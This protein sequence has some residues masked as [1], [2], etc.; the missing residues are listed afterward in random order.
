MPSILFEPER[1]AVESSQLTAFQH[2]CSS[3]VG[4]PLD[5]WAEFHAFSVRRFRDF[6]KLFTRWAPIELDGDA[7]T[8]CD[9]D[10]VEAA[11]FFPRARLSFAAHLLRCDSSADD[12]RTAL[13]ALDE[14]G[15]R[16]EVTR[17]ELRERALA[18]ARALLDAGIVPG[19]RVC[20]V[21]SN[22]A[23]AVIACLGA[24]A[25]GA[26]WS[27]TSPD[28][29][30]EG[31][32]DR[33]DQVRPRVLFYDAGYRYQG[34]VH[35][36]SPKIA[37]LA[38]ALGRMRLSVA[39]RGAA[40][41]RLRGVRS[42]EATSL[43]EL[44]RRGAAAPGPRAL[45]DLTRFAF[46]HPAYILFSSGTTG[47]PKCIVH[48]AGGTL[49]EHH[50]E[51]RLHCDLRPDDRL[52]FH[53][54]TAW[55]MW[56]WL[57]SA[58]ACKSTIVLYEGAATYPAVDS[59]WK[60]AARER[61]TVF[62]TSPSFL[63]ACKDHGVA[64]ELDFS[65]L[66]AVQSTGSVLPES[67]FRW[68]HASISHVPVQS[69][70][71]GTDILGCFLLGNPNL[72]VHTG[73]LQCKS[74]GLDVDVAPVEPPAEA[75][76][77][78]ALGYGELVC[79]TPFPSRPLGLLGDDGRRFHEAYFGRNGGAW[80]HGDWLEL[81]PTG[82]G[83]IHGRCDGVL[84]IRGV[85][86][87]PA[88]IYRALEHVSEVTA[89]MAIELREE[90]GHGSLV[91]LVVLRE[92][93]ALDAAL[94]R[95]L[96]G[97]IAARTSSAH[98]PSL[99][100]SVPELPV[101]YSGK[102]SERAATD[103]ANGRP[104][105]NGA[106]LRNP[107]SLED[108]RRAVAHARTASIDARIP[109]NGSTLEK[110]RAIWQEVLRVGVGNDDTFFELG[111]Q[112][113][114]A[115][116]LLGGVQRVFGVVLPMSALVHETPTVRKMAEAI[117]QRRIERTSSIVPLG[118]LRGDRPAYFVPGGGGLSLLMFRDISLILARDRPIFGFEYA[119]DSGRQ[120]E[121][122][123]DIARRYVDDLSAHDPVGPYTLLGFSNGA[124]TAFEMTHEIERRGRRVALLVVMDTPVPIRLGPIARSRVAAHRARYHLERMRGL[125]A[126]PM[127]DYAVGL[128]GIASTWL[129]R[130]L[131][132]PPLTAGILAAHGAPA[133]LAALD[134]QNRR[135]TIEYSGRHH[136]PVAAPI[137]LLLA[138]MGSRSALPPELDGRY[139]WKKLTRGRF[140]VL[141]VNASHLSMLRAPHMIDVAD[142][143]RD[144]LR[145]STP[146]QDGRQR[147]PRR[148]QPPRSME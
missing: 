136:L 92:G 132:R 2:F 7:E 9:G 105:E 36:A 144:L 50:K 48:G 113:L 115:V 21:A 117:E 38:Q 120:A 93:H 91:L 17:A 72:P 96:V 99:I 22:T 20:A 45:R 1:S 111:G 137:A 148:P 86:I 126:R 114:T 119:I 65:A 143:L 82:G 145:Q 39:L 124:W 107:A 69:I 32:L 60:L 127:L 55:M 25:I 135:K 122:L 24:L 71:G 47:R 94:R 104:I 41:E 81:S 121:S 5:D 131:G 6:W 23:A 146:A 75:R 134:R 28:V 15:N 97:E 34:A 13:L 68:V 51:H 19:D 140:E 42:H 142:A 56:N 90:T 84:N 123:S 112:S 43:D 53:S 26:T 130:R 95:R 128:G 49:V 58:L 74:L 14:A 141:R 37:R 40:H 4:T 85:R 89:S 57:V 147:Q 83:R 125:G 108:I 101:T 98:V 63:Q 10:T 116:T 73:E 46:N 16:T 80:S 87:G 54:T 110:V 118:G 31:I 18:V 67:L 12:A 76:A 77:R 70:S 11:R 64:G 29:G 52:Y 106:A 30:F 44:E 139:E 8:V 133:E 35:D 88:E 66:R 3:A 102:A 129:R 27:S 62:G 109:A 33:F 100:V 78:C 79:R 138:S 59:L 61:I 103:A